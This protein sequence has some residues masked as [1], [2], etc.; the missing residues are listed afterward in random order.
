MC[1]PPWLEII[2]ECSFGVLGSSTNESA[3]HRPARPARPAA[4]LFISV[5]IYI[6]I[7]LSISQLLTALQCSSNTWPLHLRSRTWKQQH[8]RLL[9]H[10][11]RQRTQSLCA[12]STQRSEL[13]P[14]F[15]RNKCL[16]CILLVFVVL[17]NTSVGRQKDQFSAWSF[18]REVDSIV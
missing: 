1:V 9:W 13:V 2:K 14:R 3:V 16:V 7:C 12:E 11:K 18:W 8:T 15:A 17:Q 10:I 4:C 6:Y 5:Y